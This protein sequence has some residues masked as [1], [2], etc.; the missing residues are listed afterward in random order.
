MAWYFALG[1]NDIRKVPEVKEFL[2]FLQ[3]EDV[4]VQF[5]RA[6]ARRPPRC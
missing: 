5:P 3:T 4:E 2:K 1:R 6:R